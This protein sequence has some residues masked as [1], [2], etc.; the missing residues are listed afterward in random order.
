MI[1]HVEDP[2]LLSHTCFTLRKWIPE[3]YGALLI[4]AHGRE[5]AVVR[6]LRSGVRDRAFIRCLLVK[7]S[8]IGLDALIIAIEWGDLALVRF[9]ITNGVRTAFP[10]A[11]GFD[12]ENV[13]PLVASP[14]S[15]S[16]GRPEIMKELLLSGATVDP[17]SFFSMFTRLVNE[18]REREIHLLRAFERTRDLF[19]DPKIQK[20]MALL[21]NQL[22]I[23]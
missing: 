13:S 20:Y 16:V 1:R 8:A 3:Q 12:I 23:F 2:R 17:S 15:R 21:A 9:L 19:H 10:A 7:G 5:K 18:G 14:L 6:C 4:G 11:N 22:R